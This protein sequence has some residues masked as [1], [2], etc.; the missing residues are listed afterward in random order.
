MADALIPRCF[1]PEAFEGWL[2]LHERAYG[3]CTICDDCEPAGKRRLQ[4]LGL[5]DE[6]VWGV[7]NFSALKLKQLRKANDGK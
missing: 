4:A 6:E 7:V 1:T 5:C 2:K 3:R